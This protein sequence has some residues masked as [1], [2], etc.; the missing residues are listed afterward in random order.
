MRGRRSV[1]ASYSS[2]TQHAELR[3]ARR[4][5]YNQFMRLNKIIQRDYTSFSLY[6]QIKLPLDLEIS[7]P[8]DDP[9]RLVSAFVEE[10][11]LSEL[12][13]TYG[14]IRKNQATPRQMLKLVIYAAMNRIYSSRDIRKACKRDI[15][16]MYL[17]EGMPA[18][19][20]AT[21]A[22]FISL[23]F[24][25]CA[26]VLLA[27]MSDLLYLLGEISGKTIFIDGTKIESAANKYTFVWKR[28][29]TKNQARLCTKLTSFVAECEELYG[30]RTV[31]HDQI[32]IHTLKRLK[33]QLCRVKVQ[34]GIV[35]V[36]GIGRRKTQLQKSLEQLDQYLEKLKEYTK[37]LYTL[38]DR[39]S[40]SKTDP[41]ATFMRMKEDAMLNGQLKPAYN[42]QHGVDSEYITWIDISP[43]P[44]DT[45]TLIP[46]LKDMESH[47]G[48]KYSEI[49]ADAGYESEENYLFIEGNGQTAYI[50]PQNYEI[51]KTRKYKKDISRREN[52][53]Y[54]ADRDS[55]I[56]RNGRE[57]TVTNERRSKTASGY[58]SVK[59]YYRSPDCTGCPYKTECI[60]GNNCKTPMEKRNKVLMV[61]KTMS[62]KRAEDLERITSEYGTMLRM[63]RSIQAE[64][65]FADVKED[66]NFRRY[67][68]RGKANALAES[69]LLA[70]GRNINKL[71]CKIQTGRTGSH[72]FSL[73]TA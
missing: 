47:L 64:G 71:H 25:A 7:I 28:A 43:R 37:K 63:N 68:Y 19:D 48:F 12:Y 6:Y 4:S 36:H 57:L 45:C 1:T 53:E 49:V 66:M 69:I 65:S 9:V 21:I 27:Q 22:R 31:Y 11:D 46:F 17:L 2:P 30:I 26:K 32:S 73:K 58:V 8:S 39:N 67:L 13:K 24:S 38:G 70:M 62:Q 40:Y 42:I 5:W 55:Y 29:I 50:K 41:D 18:P 61:S 33:K 10:M 23:H 3:K 52:M 35:F 15:N 44:T 14:R 51:S 59:T 60:K 16:F 34:E 56:C 20:H 54:H 72:L